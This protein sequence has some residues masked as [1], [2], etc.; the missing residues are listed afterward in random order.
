MGSN[1]EHQTIAFGVAV[2]A[3]ATNR[4]H[5]CAC[6]RYRARL[7]SNALS[8]VVVTASRTGETKIQTPRCRFRSLG[9]Q[10]AQSSLYQRP[11]SERLRPQSKHF[12]SKAVRDTRRLPAPPYSG[13]DPP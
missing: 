5:P 1:N 3:F 8:E 4:R 6:G 13:V 2:M 9:A 7:C 10:L 11:G 12:A